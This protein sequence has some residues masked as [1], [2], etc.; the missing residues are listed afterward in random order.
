MQRPQLFLL[1]QGNIDN[2][3]KPA[4]TRC[5]D[6]LVQ[7]RFKRLAVFAHGLFENRI[8]GVVPQR[9]ALLVFQHFKVGLHPGLDRE[10]VQQPLAKR[11]DRMDLQAAFR[12]ER[13]REEL[14]R[15]HH[16]GLRRDDAAK[17]FQFT[18]EFSLRQNRP[19]GQNA[20]QAVLHLR[21]RGLGV[22]QA[23]YGLR[24]HIRSAISARNIPVQQQAQ[25]AVHQ[26]RCLARARIGRHPRARLGVGGPSLVRVDLLLEGLRRHGQISPSPVACHSCTRARCANAS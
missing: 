24:P 3:A 20:E 9:D 10:T 12:I 1:R 5:H 19:P 7:S 17:V 13:N 26:N 6:N 22:G 16:V 21:C 8:Y 18:R 14:P 15:P 23:Q 4:L 2:I 25:H 11:V